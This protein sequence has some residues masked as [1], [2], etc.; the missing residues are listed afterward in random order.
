MNVPRSTE[1]AADTGRR[2]KIRKEAM[3]GGDGK[4]KIVGRRC[5]RHS[6][7]SRDLEGARVLRIGGGYESATNKICAAARGEDT[8]RKGYDSRLG[9]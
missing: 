1:E 9:C 6:D 5:K 3:Q 2:R 8:G 7:P 4:K